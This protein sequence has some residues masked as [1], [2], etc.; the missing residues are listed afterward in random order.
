MIL[1]VKEVVEKTDNTIS[2]EVT[3]WLKSLMMS[4][5]KTHKQTTTNV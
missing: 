5:R 2:Q 3:L 4:S 1:A